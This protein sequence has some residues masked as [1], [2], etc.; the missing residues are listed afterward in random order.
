M[1]SDTD[2]DATPA[3]AGDLLLR[4]ASNGVLVL[5]PEEADPLIAEITLALDVVRARCGLLRLLRHSGPT[6]DADTRQLDQLLVDVAFAEQT[7]PGRLE[8]A[9]CELPKYIRAFEIAKTRH[10]DAD[11]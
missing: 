11:R 6:P 5:A 9:L 8:R 3:F 4:L 1:D 2:T 7:A 10:A